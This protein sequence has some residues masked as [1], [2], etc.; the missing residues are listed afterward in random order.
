[1]D[2][3]EKRGEC[4]NRP[5]QP[6]EQKYQKAYALRE[7]LAALA[8]QHARA[9]QLSPNVYTPPTDA[10]TIAFLTEMHKDVVKAVQ[11]KF[12]LERTA[13]QSGRRL[14][15]RRGQ[16]PVVA[17]QHPDEPGK[18][19][20]FH[21]QRDE[22]SIVKVGRTR[23][24]G[25]RRLRQW[26]KTLEPES[27]VQLVELFRIN[28]RYNMFAERLVHTVLMCENLTRV[29][30]HTGQRLDEFFRVQN[31]MEL[32]LFLILCIAYVDDWCDGV[33][34]GFR[35]TSPIYARWRALGEV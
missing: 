1:M 7:Q 25:N 20:C 13:I 5:L 24:R 19:Y 15:L 17:D 30:P 22:S 32:K 27:G 3:V 28:T 6:T 9:P 34:A 14:P 16:H 11:A 18:I 35:A 29:N 2:T 12:A 4:T 23:Q 33:W 26:E 31:A 8:F 21:D 10:Y